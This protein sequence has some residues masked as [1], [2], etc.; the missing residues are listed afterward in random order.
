MRI[1]LFCIVSLAMLLLISCDKLNIGKKKDYRETYLGTYKARLYCE[2]FSIVPEPPS[3]IYSDETKDI[4]VEKGS[5]DSTLKINGTEYPFPSSAH[6]YKVT[7]YGQQA[8]NF[9]SLAFFVRSKKG[10]DSL[11]IKKSSGSSNIYEVCITKAG[12]LE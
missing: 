10:N 4:L 5:T 3:G 1:Y 11:I 2:R 7:D 9:D 12:K 6:Y 8:Y